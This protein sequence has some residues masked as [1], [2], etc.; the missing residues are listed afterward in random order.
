MD[1]NYLEYGADQSQGILLYPLTLDC[2]IC[3]DR[4]LEHHW[5]STLLLNSKRG[6]IDA[7][8]ASRISRT[9]AVHQVSEKHGRDVPQPLSDCALLNCKPYHVQLTREITALVAMLEYLYV[10]R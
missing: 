5:A 2:I 4:R 10:S 7:L 6:A 9:K 3:D 8:I 1:T